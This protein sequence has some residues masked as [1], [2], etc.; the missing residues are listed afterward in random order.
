MCCSFDYFSAL[1]SETELAPG[2]P[3]AFNISFMGWMRFVELTKLVYVALPCIATLLLLLLCNHFVNRHHLRARAGLKRLHQ[4]CI[5]ELERVED[6]YSK[7]KRFHHRTRW[8]YTTAI[9]AAGMRAKRGDVRPEYDPNASASSKLHTIIRMKQWV[10]KSHRSDGS[11]TPAPRA[12]GI[13]LE[14]PLG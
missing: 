5:S 7:A 3:D 4:E 10:G 6:E 12:V 14:Q 1:Y 13:V 9:H 8:R 11:P 2:E